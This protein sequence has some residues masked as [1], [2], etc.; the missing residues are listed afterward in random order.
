M[1]FSNRMFAAAGVAALGVM[2]CANSASA[3]QLTIDSVVPQSNFLGTTGA[4]NPLTGTPY[5]FTGQGYN[6]LTSIDSIAITLTM[7]DGKTGVGELDRDNLTLGLDGFDTGIKLND[8]MAGN[9]VTLT[10][11]GPIANAS[12][13]LAALKAD[14]QLV[15]SVLDATPGDSTIGLSARLDTELGITG[16]VADNGGGQS[17][18]LPAAVLIAPL[19]ASLAGAFARR[20]RKA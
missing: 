10:I 5:D 7:S 9:I 8:F 4:S 15:G 6:N 18:P 2:A 3:A 16:T 17:V 20:M 1:K 14:G 13:I 11:S 19:G 12:Q